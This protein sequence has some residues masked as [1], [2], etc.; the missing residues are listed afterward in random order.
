MRSF[1]KNFMLNQCHQHC[2]PNKKK[3]SIKKYSNVEW[4]NGDIKSKFLSNFKLFKVLMRSVSSNPQVCQQYL[5]KWIFCIW[6]MSVIW[7]T[8]SVVVYEGKRQKLQGKT[9]FHKI[10]CCHNN[11]YCSI[12]GRHNA[13]IEWTSWVTISEKTGLQQQKIDFVCSKP[14][15]VVNGSDKV[16]KQY[17]EIKRKIV[18]M[19]LRSY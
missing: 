6:I 19:Y 8:W 9:G 15:C 2:V 17:F 3:T 1:L 10:C 16:K 13:F 18:Q 7:K 12:K 11:N 5:T 4:I 14:Q